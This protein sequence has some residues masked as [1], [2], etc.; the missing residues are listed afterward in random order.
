MSIARF[1]GNP[2]Q[3]C[4]AS[5]AIWDYHTMFVTCRSTQVNTARAINE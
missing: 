4:G 3:R 5:P 1:M 2:S